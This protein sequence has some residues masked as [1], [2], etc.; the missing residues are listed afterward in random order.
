MESFRNFRIE[1]ARAEYST[2]YHYSKETQ[3]WS[4]FKSIV[5]KDFNRLYDWLKEADS[6][7]S[8][9]VG[10][11]IDFYQGRARDFIEE[12]EEAQSDNIIHLYRTIGLY[13]PESLNKEDLGICWTWDPDNLDY[14]AKMLVD[15]ESK[16]EARLHIKANLDNIDWFESFYLYCIYGY[17][18][19]ELRLVNPEG[20]KLEG[21]LFLKGH[22]S[23]QE[24]LR[25][26]GDFEALIPQKDLVFS[27]LKSWMKY[28]PVNSEGKV[29]LS[30]SLVVPNW[31]IKD[32]RLAVSFGKVKGSFIVRSSSLATLEG[33]PDYVG[34]EF[35][36]SYTSITSLKGAPERIKG[37]FFCEHTKIETLEGL[38]EGAHSYHLTHN[39]NLTSLNGSP[40]VVRGSFHIDFCPSLTSLEGAPRMIGGDFNFAGCRG[41]QYLDV[42]PEHVGGDVTFSL[43]GHFVDEYKGEVEGHIWA[44]ERPN[45]STT[46]EEARAEYSTKYHY[47]GETSK[48]S[49][50]KYTAEHNI[51]KIIRWLDYINTYKASSKLGWTWE[52]II[53]RIEK[54]IEEV[55]K[56]SSDNMIH[57]Y[58]T[59]GLEDLDSLNKEDL[60]VCW[61]WDPSLLDSLSDVLIEGDAKYEVR[62]HI[63]ASLDNIDWYESLYL[64]CRYGNNEKELRLV[65]PEGI[66]LTGYVVI[67]GFYSQQTLVKKWGATAQIVPPSLPKKNGSSTL[68]KWLEKHPKNAKGKIDVDGDVEV[69][70][71]MVK[72]GKLL[73]SF[74]RVTGNF[75]FRVY[76]WEGTVTTLEGSPE[77]VGGNY[78]CMGTNISSFDGAPKEVGGKFDC[79]G[80][81]NITTLKGLPKAHDYEL[82]S[83]GNL[84]SL[85]G[86][87][88]EVEGNFDI[89][90]CTSLRTLR[91][92]PRKV[93]G[94]FNFIGCRSLK[95]L[96]WAPEYVGGNVYLADTEFKIDDYREEVGGEVRRWNI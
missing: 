29:D 18:E 60:G 85:A 43:T 38:P 86:S 1:E 11:D 61:T 84:K 35:D 96:D 30:T 74:G 47:S 13:S 90:Y 20:S 14:L 91:G 72:D 12:I 3:K 50:F 93:G 73:V 51:G 41:L 89:E 95:S 19:K 7:S 64:F 46:L 82:T 75:E 15:P 49:E 9:K 59:I 81:P 92:A 66:K 4:E 22:Y 88:K 58:R 79:K 10:G 33:C 2:K 5:N 62:L 44:K 77:Y 34:G 32:G 57:L 65:N 8:T 42:V 56:N 54:F 25:E 76:P 40:S 27:D 70:G 21:Y 16:Y 55:E 87:P 6:K 31:L 37:S 68:G 78:S 69:K 67:K 39:E 53:D 63:K 48:W 80:K 26:W 23:P 83:L 94:N 17:T 24:V 45:S 52:Y 28:H 71:W 36:C